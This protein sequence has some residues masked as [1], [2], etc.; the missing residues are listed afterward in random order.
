MPAGK[1][2][3]QRHEQRFNG[4][5]GDIAAIPRVAP[6]IGDQITEPARGQR[7]IVQQIGPGF[8]IVHAGDRLEQ[9][10]C[11]VFA[12]NVLN[13]V[14]Q[15]FDTEVGR[16]RSCLT[17]R[18][19]AEMVIQF[20]AAECRLLRFR[21]LVGGGSRAEQFHLRAVGVEPRLDPVY[22]IVGLGPDPL[23]LIAI[24]IEI[25]IAM[26]RTAKVA[27]QAVERVLPAGCRGFQVD[28]QFLV[29]AFDNI[30]R[31]DLRVGS[32][33]CGLVVGGAVR[34]RTRR[35]RRRTCLFRVRAVSGSEC[36]CR[37]CGQ[38]KDAQNPRNPSE[39]CHRTPANPSSR[40]GL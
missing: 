23:Q 12:A 21:R 11:K 25:R 36:R 1:R 31:V 28:A 14:E 30:G 5:A 26:T 15:I 7:D 17:G 10:G 33:N 19:Q 13:C 27:F 34:C 16:V 35:G 38:H 2:Q 40:G 3:K 8:V 29:E 18:K 39:R 4:D 6:P 22:D 9:D 37:D 24:L 20:R 32:R